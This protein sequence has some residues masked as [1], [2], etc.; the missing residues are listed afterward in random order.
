[1]TLGELINTLKTYPEHHIVLH[2]FRK[3]HSYRGYYD[4]LAF[5][6]ITDGSPTTVGEMLKAAEYANG[7]TFEGWKGDQFYMDLD[8]T[9]WIAL[10]G[11]TNADDIPLTRN[12]LQTMLDEK[13][14]L[15]KS[16]IIRM[17]QE[18]VGL[19][20]PIDPSKLVK[21]ADFVDKKYPEWVTSEIQVDLRAWAHRIAKA[22]Q[23]DGRESED[24]VL[25]ELIF[26]RKQ[27]NEWVC[28]S[29]NE[30]YPGPPHEG[31]ACVICPKCGGFTVPRIKHENNALQQ[32]INELKAKL[33]Q[34]LPMGNDKLRFVSGE[35][36]YEGKL[37]G[38][39]YL[40][41]RDHLPMGVVEKL[42]RDSQDEES[43]YTNGY[44]AD[45]AKYLKEQL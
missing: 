8:T 14:A 15:D 12:D 4:Q 25:D 40:L 21:L 19:I 29:C 23:A 2:G 22:Q 10:E 41:M 42:V 5:E 44:L 32:E 27:V 26:Y 39:L 30:V 1:M 24:G 18:A 33:Q 6:P 38:F 3:P 43:I 20:K 45:Y 17:L 34:V 36:S 16:T 11:T 7:R 35:R 28:A 13:Y 31:A 37:L 9:V